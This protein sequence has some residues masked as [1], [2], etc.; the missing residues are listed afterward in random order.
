[1]SRSGYKLSVSQA[2]GDRIAAL[3]REHGCGLADVVREACAPVLDPTTTPEV[4]AAI[5]ERARSGALIA[6]RRRARASNAAGLRG[7]VAGR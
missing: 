1:M 3:A 4:L 7:V 5:V 6:E 2:T